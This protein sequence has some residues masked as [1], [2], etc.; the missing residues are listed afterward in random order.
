MLM[1][2]VT[3][4]LGLAH[5]ASGLGASLNHAL[6][7]SV[8]TTGCVAAGAGSAKLAAASVPDRSSRRSGAEGQQFRHG[9]R[10]LLLTLTVVT[11]MEAATPAGSQARCFG[12]MAVGRTRNGVHEGLPAPAKGGL[13]T[14]WPRLAALASGSAS[15]RLRVRTWV[16][17][18]WSNLAR[19]VTLW[20]MTW[21]VVMLPRRVRQQLRRTDRRPY[22]RGRRRRV[23]HQWNPTEWLP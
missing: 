1:L 12:A 7:S 13:R 4:L 6:P 23:R 2:V 15:T 14:R 19:F 21:L 17:S 10:A 11:P 20:C 3:L 5:G 8:A 22:S 18:R 9:Q 16:T